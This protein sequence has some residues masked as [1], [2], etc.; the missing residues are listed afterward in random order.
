MNRD[1]LT[2]VARLHA[3]HQSRTLEAKSAGE[4]QEALATAH[5]SIVGLVLERDGER[6]TRRDAE[7]GARAARKSRD[8]TM[9]ALKQAMQALKKFKAEVAERQCEA[10]ALRAQV[11]TEQRARKNAERHVRAERHAREEAF[12]QLHDVRTGADEQLRVSARLEARCQEMS[13]Q[14]KSL[15]GAI[16]QAEYVAYCKSQE[17]ALL[18]GQLDKERR[19]RVAAEDALAA[20]KAAAEEASRTMTERP[21][22]GRKRLRLAHG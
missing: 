17:H 2:L 4:L 20:L 19:T 21:S 16:A 13:A 7:T 9:R 5:E 8:A 14:L 10:E 18:K 3:E 12:R 1:Q 15:E 22:R 11:E 6:R